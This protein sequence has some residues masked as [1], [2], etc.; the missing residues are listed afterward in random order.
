MKPCECWY[1]CKY[2]ENGWCHAYAETVESTS[3]NECE[4]CE[5]YECDEDDSIT[6]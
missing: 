4:A 2:Y 5:A 3:E 1:D 6:N